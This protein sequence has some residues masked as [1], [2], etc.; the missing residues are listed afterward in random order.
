MGLRI[1][2][3]STISKFHAF[4]IS[5][6]LLLD[7]LDGGII[8]LSYANTCLQFTMRFLKL[9]FKTQQNYH[10]IQNFEKPK[11]KFQNH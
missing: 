5:F 8:G 1:S 6:L 10:L 3:L 4:L 7:F 2:Y 11:F 9:Q